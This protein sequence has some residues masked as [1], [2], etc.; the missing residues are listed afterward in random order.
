MSRFPLTKPCPDFAGLLQILKGKKKPEKVP[1]A[2]LFIDFEVIEFI[3]DKLLGEKLPSF[4]Q[5]K[6]KKIKE[7]MAGENIT[8][9]SD[10]EE[11]VYIKGLINFYYRMGYD[12]VQDTIPVEYYRAMIAPE[13][14]LAEDTAGITGGISRGKRRWA[15]EKRGKITSWREFEEFPWEKIRQIEMEEY[16]N[17]LTENLP[18]GMKL[19]TMQ[20]FFEN[21]FEYILGYE[22]L[23]YLL[24][25]EPGLVKEV[26]NEMGDIVYEYYQ[27]VISLDSVGGIFH[28]DDMGFKTGTFISPKMLQE[29]VFPWHKKFAS[30]AHDHGKPFWLHSCGDERQVINDLIEDV[31]IDAYHSFEDTITPVVKFKKEYGDRIAVLGG[32]DMHKLCTLDERNLRKYVKDILDQCMPGGRYALGSGNSIANYVPVKNYLIMLEEGLNWNVPSR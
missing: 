18:E 6:E 19:M 3:S 17:F 32:V 20:V 31:K 1:F 11:K 14:T 12:Y 5:L 28:A 29:L 25:D 10:P 27:K 13:G 26:H 23:F 15:E 30:L 9:L 16:Y 7:F 21:I 8:L 22:G 24:Y 2:E 4:A